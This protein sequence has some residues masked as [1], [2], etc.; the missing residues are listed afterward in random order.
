MTDPELADR[1]YVEP[2]TVEAARADHRSREARRDPADRRRTDGAQSGDRSRRS[3]RAQEVQRAR[4]SA[5]R[6]RRSRSPRIAC[7][8]AMRCARSASTCRRAASPRRSTRRSSSWRRSGFPAIIRP[9]FTLGGVGGGIAYNLEEFKEI[10]ARGLSLSPMHEILIEQSVIGWKEFE[11]EVMRDGADNFVVICS[12][13]NIDPM[14]VHTGDSI[15]VAPALTL[16]DKEYQRMRDAGAAHH[17][18][19]RRRDRRLEHPVRDQSGRRP[20]G[21]HRDEPARVAIL[22]ARVEGHRLPDREDRRQARARL[23]P[24]RDSQRHHARHARVLRADHR[25]RRRQD[26]ALELREVPAGRS[27]ADHADEVGG[28]GDG[29]R[30]HLQGG[31]PQRHP[32]ARARPRRAAVHAP[33]RGRRCGG[34]GAG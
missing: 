28:R 25:L 22:G 29:D 34:P 18:P 21:R 16:T 24:A 27:H 31:V 9:S 8:S 17:P 2:L 20:H 6:C 12:I 3:G 1:T 19:R 4:S 11:L 33:G 14:G 32:I 15:T 5:R 7:C 10:A 13:E 30:P 26:P 23:P